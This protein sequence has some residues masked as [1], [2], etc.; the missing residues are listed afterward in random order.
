MFNSLPQYLKDNK[1]QG[2][3]RTLLLLKKS[4]ERGL[5]HTL[6]D[7]YV[8]LKGIVTNSPKDIGPFT[9]AFYQ[10]FLG[11]DINRGE[12]LD[13][14]VLRS[15]TF[16]D[17]LKHQ[18]IEEVEIPDVKDLVESFLND[19]HL[20]SYDIQNILR[21]EDILEK[22]DPNF[23]DTEGADDAPID[24]VKRAADYSNIPLE[25]LLERM[26]KVLEQQRRRHSGGTHWVGTGGASPYGNGSA[27]AGGIRVGGQGGGKMARRVINDKNFY[28]VDTHVILQD[29][30]IDVALAFLKGIEEESVERI[31]D[32]PATITEGV[33][34]GAL[35]LP[36]ERD[37]I[38]QKVQVLLLIDNGGWSMSPYIDSVT[39]LFSK[40]KRRFAHDLKTY[41]FHNT[42]YGGV[43]KDAFRSQNQFE[44]IENICKLDKNYA[45]FIIGDADMASYELSK[46]SLRDWQ[47]LK[48]RFERIVWLNPMDLKYW[49]GSLTVNMLQQI[50]DMFPL[51]PYGIEKGVAHMNRKRQFGKAH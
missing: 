13:A 17:W 48:T 26:K 23:K 1:L 2:D 3:V 49:A 4:M 41:Y 6:G 43:Y 31:L 14:A 40:M 28:P 10:Y 51:S 9:K 33:K 36:Q 18:G 47:A 37:K 46:D 5:V 42:I 8:V 45:V 34:Q 38:D 7:L 50:F 16:K 27:A 24:T 32:I 30:N 11:I 21:G 20:T 29:N 15:E 22:D 19:V 25:E 35:F 12:T 44:T 39:K